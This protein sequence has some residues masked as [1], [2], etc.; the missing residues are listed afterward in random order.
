[1]ALVLADND[2]VE[3]RNGLDAALSPQRDR[4]RALIHP[5]AGDLDVLR[6][7]G[8]R[9]I[10]DGHVVGTQPIGV[11]PDV[12]LALTSADDE[13][14]AHAAKAFDL[15]PQDLVRV[16]GDVTDRLVR[17]ERQRE[18]GRRVGVE[19]GDARLLNRLGQQR[20]DAVDLVAHLLGSHVAVLVEH[21][22]DDD[23]RD[24]LGRRRGQRVDS[25]D[26]VDGFLDLVRDFRF[27]LLGRGSGL[28][29]GHSHGGEVDLRIAIHAELEERK[30]P[31]DRQ[32]QDQDARKYRTTNT[33]R[34][35]PLHD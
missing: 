17:A 24:A 32:R 9:D 28:H 19:L 27:D 12:H 8:P 3:L 21:E 7:K 2:V 20:K 29:R 10:G 26:R 14:L 34:C 18:D 5:A 22:R 33:Q 23:L 6:L 16:L 25:A 11:E 30:R 35:K 13:H 31:D 15:P 4:L 1:M